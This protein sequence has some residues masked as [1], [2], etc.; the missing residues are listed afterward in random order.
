MSSVCYTVHSV[1]H[2]HTLALTTKM[3][4]GWLLATTNYLAVT[5]GDSSVYL[6]YIPSSF[7]HLTAVCLYLYIHHLLTP[8]PGVVHGSFLI[9][10]HVFPCLSLSPSPYL[11]PSPPPLLS[12]CCFRVLC[13]FLMC[14]S[15]TLKHFP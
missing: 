8:P 7:Q 6:L 4:G 5:H 12:S 14:L 3:I 9:T 13:L 2:K 10:C 15:F 1:V 11:F